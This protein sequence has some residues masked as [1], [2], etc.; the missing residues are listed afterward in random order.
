MKKF[1]LLLSV[2]LYSFAY[3]EVNVKVDSTIIVTPEGIGQYLSAL[4]I[5]RGDI[6]ESKAAININKLFPNEDFSK[7]EDSPANFILSILKGY[8]ILLPQSWDRLL[9]NTDNLNL[10]NNTNY[11]KTFFSKTDKYKCV[12]VLKNSTK[13]YTLTFEVLTWKKDSNY[14]LHVSDK[15]SEFNSIDKLLKDYLEK[16]FDIADEQ[17]NANSERYSYLYNKNAFVKIKNKTIPSF[18]SFVDKLT[19]SIKEMQSYSELMSGQKNTHGKELENYW[20]DLISYIQKNNYSDLQCYNTTIDNISYK[21][22]DVYTDVYNVFLLYRFSSKNKTYT[23]SC[24]ATL[25]DE[26]WYLLDISHIEEEPK[27]EFRF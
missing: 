21:D 4:L 7:F 13:F 11:V 6:K 15:L 12:A 23:F 18:N 16:R 10:D 14:V 20:I 17:T 27:I 26:N 19:H 25:V 9:K 3:G 1:I 24:F 5:N 8:E 22:T 2:F